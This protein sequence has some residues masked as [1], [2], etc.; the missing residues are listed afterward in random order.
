MGEPVPTGEGPPV[1]AVVCNYNGEHY[2]RE[3][4]GS[5]LA[6]AYPLDEILVVDNGST[7]ASVELVRAEFPSVRLL[8]LPDNGGPCVARNAGLRAARNRLVLAVDN[9]AMLQPDTLEGLVEAVG[10]GA[11]AAQPRSVYADEPARVHYDGGAFHYVGL[12]ALRNFARPLAEAEGRGTVDVDGLIA[13]CILFDREAYEEVGGYD[14]DLFI[15]FEDMDLSMRLRIA[16]HRL[17]SVE[18]KLVL[19]RGGTPGISFRGSSYP[20]FRAYYH[21]RNRWLVMLKNYRWRTLL[22]A[23]PGILLYEVVWA[24]FTLRSGHFRAHLAG[25]LALLG[26]LRAVL[27]RRREVQALRRVSDRELLVEGPLTFSPQLVAKP[28][29]A[30][31]AA[32]LDACLR[33]AWRAMRWLSR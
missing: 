31:L 2:L 28:G 25:K 26:G 6:S 3:C 1:S 4:L 22:A 24:L 29:A 32:G 21:S 33:L 12:Y 15:L 8:R 23:A 9:D 27:A 11:T 7:D 18:D 14:E 20:K 30:R 17:V 13:I 10:A 16:G 19:H 5:L